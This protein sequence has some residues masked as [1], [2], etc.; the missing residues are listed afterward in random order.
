M[1]AVTIGMRCAW[2]TPDVI[3][4]DLAPLLERPAEAPTA[5]DSDSALAVRAAHASLVR[6]AR[7]DGTRWR[8]SCLYR[9]VAECLVL[10]AFGLPA[11]VVIGV[12]T[13][14]ATS[15]VIA[16]AW[17]ECEGVRCM[18]TRGQAELATLVSRTA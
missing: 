13:A 11:Y 12:G 14:A 16:H 7:V 1:R 17:V 6:L 5:S 3:A 2:T 18:S 4:R 8:N 15:D 9:S 10:R